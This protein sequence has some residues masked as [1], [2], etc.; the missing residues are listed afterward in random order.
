MLTYVLALLVGLGSLAIYAAFFMSPGFGRRSDLVWSGVGLFYALVLWVCARRITGGV[1]LGQTASVA[2][3]GWLGWQAFQFRWDITPPD[4]RASLPSP[5]DVAQRFKGVGTFVQEKLSGLA[6]PE[7]RSQLQN[8][9][10]RA[11]STVKDKVQQVTGATNAPAAPTN[12]AGQTAP[13]VPPLPTPPIAPPPIAPFPPAIPT[14]T[15]IESAA[16]DPDGVPNTVRPALETAIP[17]KPTAKPELVKPANPISTT[18]TQLPAQAVKVFKILADLVQDTLKGATQK[19]PSKEM[20]TINRPAPAPK[21]APA[22]VTAPVASPEPTSEALSEPIAE[23]VTL[24]TTVLTDMT[25]ADMMTIEEEITLLN[26]EVEADPVATVPVE[27]LVETE[28]VKL[29][30]ETEDIP[31]PIRPHPPSLELVEAALQDAEEKDLPADPPAP[32][33]PSES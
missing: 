22:A 17:V 9:S 24:E 32:L 20:I 25:S 3:L 11:F 14:D 26:N 19:K 4:Q 5:D 8:Q 28:A 27:T 13:R 7:G 12:V 33:E 23:V 16:A 18:L 2:L 30:T 10:T 15:A 21:V 6:T 31:E 29:E 1:L